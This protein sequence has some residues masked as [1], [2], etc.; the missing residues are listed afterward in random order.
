MPPP[1]YN[2]MLNDPTLSTLN[3]KC[4]RT[5]LRYTLDVEC[6]HPLLRWMSNAPLHC[7][8]N[9]PST[10]DVECPLYTGCRIPPP[11]LDVECTTT[12]DVE[13]PP[14]LDAP[15]ESPTGRDSR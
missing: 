13:C 12:L 5:H 8:S 2:W 3:V 9:A 14:T 7:M 4:P 1:P 10:L 6:L 11:T 15:T